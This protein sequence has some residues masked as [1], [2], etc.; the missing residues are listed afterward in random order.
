MI[1]QLNIKN[2]KIF[3]EL[4]LE[5]LSRFTLL[6]GYNNVGKSTILEAIFMLFDLN[7]PQLFQNTY[8]WRGAPFTDW[9]PESL[10]GPTF[11]NYDLKKTIEANMESGIGKKIYQ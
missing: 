6:S 10:W 9:N 4:H 8:T 2:F 5:K 3:K 11:N 1:T 7:N